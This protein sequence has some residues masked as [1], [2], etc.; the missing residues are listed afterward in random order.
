MKAETI[1]ELTVATIASMIS[2][3]V[4]IPLAFLAIKVIKDYSR[5]EPLLN[6]IRLK[7]DQL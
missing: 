7:E 1:E 4:G 5:V 3:I 2:N 6:E